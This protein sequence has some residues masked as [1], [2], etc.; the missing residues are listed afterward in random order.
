MSD[1]DVIYQETVRRFFRKGSRISLLSCGWNDERKAQ[2]DLL[3]FS[4]FCRCPPLKGSCIEVRILT[5][6]RKWKALLYCR[7]IYIP[8]SRIGGYDSSG[9]HPVLGG[10]RFCFMGK[11]FLMRQK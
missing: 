3:E 5:E 1:V 11:A 2:E 9:F 7:R 4:T 8:Y 6:A 10:S